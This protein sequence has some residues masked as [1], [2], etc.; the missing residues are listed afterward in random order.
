MSRLTIVVGL[1]IMCGAA[2]LASKIFAPLPVAK[3][4]VRPPV[5][6]RAE[7]APAVVTRPRPT[8]VAAPVAKTP[9]AAVKAEQDKRFAELR[10]E[11]RAIRDALMKSDPKAAQAYQ[12][13]RQDPNYTALVER[14]RLLESNWAG[15]TDAERSMILNEVNMIRQQTTGMVMVELSKLNSQPAQAQPQPNA[16]RVDTL[17]RGASPQ[18]APPPPAPIIYM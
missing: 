3:P 12:N 9:D 17:T 13:L 1:L 2:Y 5:V 6:V 14:R 4:G 18:A 15:A 8:P 11:G 7:P 10:D 16:G